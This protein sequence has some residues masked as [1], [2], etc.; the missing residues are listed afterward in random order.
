MSTMV[1]KLSLHRETLRNLDSQEMGRVNGGE[2]VLLCIAATLA[3]AGGR[4]GSRI[5]YKRRN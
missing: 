5:R 4:G 2:S 1:Q 3:L